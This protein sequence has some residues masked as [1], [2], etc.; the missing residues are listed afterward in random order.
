[1]AQYVSVRILLND[2]IMLR[3]DRE[4]QVDRGIHQDRVHQHDRE[5]QHGQGTHPDRVHQHDR[6]IHPDLD[7]IQIRDRLLRADRQLLKDRRLRADRLLDL[8]LRRK[9]TNRT[10]M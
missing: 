8:R 4:F 10:K 5:T 7:L 3:L 2:R 1:M 6:E 9:M